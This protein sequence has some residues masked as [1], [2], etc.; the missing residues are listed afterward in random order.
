MILV[1][2]SWNC[3]TKWR[4]H[5]SENKLSIS[6]SFLVAYNSLFRDWSAEMVLFYINMSSGVVLVQVLVREPNCEGIMGKILLS[7][8]GDRI[9]QPLSD[10]ILFLLIP[11][12]YDHELN[13]PFIFIKSKTSSVRYLFSKYLH[14]F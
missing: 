12:L 11:S 3:I 5:Y 7:F 8:P 10:I 2:T 13:I 9:S 14:W 4:I 1:L 6:P